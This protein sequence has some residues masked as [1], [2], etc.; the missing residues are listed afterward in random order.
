MTR[1]QRSLPFI[2]VRRKKENIPNSEGDDSVQRKRQAQDELRSPAKRVALQNIEPANEAVTASCQDTKETKAPKIKLRPNRDRLKMRQ[3][4]SC[5]PSWLSGSVMQAAARGR[6]YAVAH[7]AACF[8]Q[9]FVEPRVGARALWEVAVDTMSMLN[10]ASMQA[11]EQRGS[12]LM[13]INTDGSLA[14]V[15]CPGHG[16]MMALPRSALYERDVSRP[17]QMQHICSQQSI[18]DIS[19]SARTPD[20]LATCSSA[21]NSVH[22]WNATT[23][24]CE[25]TLKVHEPLGRGSAAGLQA[26]QT[27]KD[28]QHMLA[29]GGYGGTVHLWDARASARSSMALP[30]QRPVVVTSLLCCPETHT[31]AAGSSRGDLDIWDLRKVGRSSA[32]AV[33][34]ARGMAQAT[35]AATLNLPAAAADHPTA[36]PYAVQLRLSAGCMSAGGLFQGADAPADGAAVAATG[37]D[38]VGAAGGRLAM[39]RSAAVVSA[40]A[41]CAVDR[42]VPDPGDRQRVAFS[43]ACGGAGVLNLAS[44][45]VTHVFNPFMFQPR[46]PHAL[47]GCSKGSAGTDIAWS[48]DSSVLY[49][50]MPQAALDLAA[51]DDVDSG[52]VLRVDG[53]S[54]DGCAGELGGWGRFEG[55]SDG[56]APRRSL[57]CALDVAQRSALCCAAAR[58]WGRGGDAAPFSMEW[59]REGRRGGE[60]GEGGGEAG[61]GGRACMPGSKLG[62]EVERTLYALD[63][64][65]HY[66][67]RQY[68]Q[69]LLEDAKAQNVIV[70][71][72]TGSGKTLIAAL[73]AK[74]F[75]DGHGAKVI[76]MMVPTKLLVGQQAELFR[77]YVADNIGEYT[78]DRG[79]DGWNQE[80]W[81]EEMRTHKILIMTPKILEDLLTCGTVKFWDISL[82]IFDEAHHCSGDHPYAQIMRQYAEAAKPD[83]PHILGMTASP[84]NSKVTSTEKLISSLVGLEK[85]MDS[86][87]ITIH[88]AALKKLQETVPVP[89]TDD[90]AYTVPSFSVTNRQNLMVVFAVQQLLLH[91]DLLELMRQYENLNRKRM[92]VHDLHEKRGFVGLDD[93]GPLMRA[94]EVGHWLVHKLCFAMVHQGPFCATLI[95]QDYFRNCSS[96]GRLSTLGCL[97]EEQQFYISAAVARRTRHTGPRPPR[98]STHAEMDAVV[99]DLNAVLERIR[100]SHPPQCRR[101]PSAEECLRTA[102]LHAVLLCVRMLVSDPV[103]ADCLS[104]QTRKLLFAR[105]DTR[106]AGSTPGH[107]NGARRVSPAG[108]AGAAAAAPYVDTHMH[109]VAAVLDAALHAVP[110]D[111]LEACT[112]GGPQHEVARMW[113][114]YMGCDLVTDRVSKTLAKLYHTGAEAHAEQPDSKWAALVFVQ[115]QTCSLALDML[116]QRV[117]PLKTVLRTNSLRSQNAIMSKSNQGDVISRFRCGVL[118]ALFSTSVAEEGLDIQ[119]CS[120]V[121]CYDVPKRPLSMVQ[122]VGRARSRGSRVFFMR[123]MQESGLKDKHNLDQMEQYTKDMRTAVYGRS[124]LDAALA[125]LRQQEPSE[126]STLWLGDKAINAGRARTMLAQY[127]QALMRWKARWQNLL[128]GNKSTDRRAREMLLSRPRESTVTVSDGPILE[129]EVTLHLPP[130]APVRHITG[131]RRSS[132]VTA[133]ESAVLRMIGALW[134]HGAFDE[135][136][137]PV[138]PEALREVEQELTLEDGGAAGWTSRQTLR[139]PPA[140]AVKRRPPLHLDVR[141]APLDEAAAV[142]SHCF[143]ATTLHL[144][145]FDTT[146]LADSN[147]SG[148][149]GGKNAAAAGADVGEKLELGL[150]LLLLQ[151]LPEL[152]GFTVYDTPPGA[153]GAPVAYECRLRHCR[154][155]SLTMEQLVKVQRF[156]CRMVQTACGTK[157][158]AD[159]L[160]PNDTAEVISNETWVESSGGEYY[161]IV[162]VCEAVEAAGPGKA[163]KTSRAASPRAARCV[164]LDERT[165]ESALHPSAA[166]DGAAAQEEVY[167]QMMQLLRRSLDP[168][169]SPA[170]QAEAQ[171][172]MDELLRGRVLSTLHQPKLAYRFRGISHATIGDKFPDDRQNEYGTFLDYYTRRYEYPPAFFNP[173]APLLRVSIAASAVKDVNCLVRPRPPHQADAAADTTGEPAAADA[174]V[175]GDLGPTD[176]EGVPIEAAPASA[177]ADHLGQ[178]RAAEPSTQPPGQT[179]PAQ[180]G[181]VMDLVSASDES[182]AEAAS[183]AAAPAAA[184]PE[185][186][187]TGAGAARQQPQRDIL[188]PLEVCRV[189]RLQAGLLRSL[190]FLP[191]LIYRVE[192]L[193]AA[194]E[195]WQRL[196]PPRVPEALRRP[197]FT[198]RVLEALTP[199]GTRDS[200][201]SERLEFLG[202]GILKGI[203]AKHVFQTQGGSEGH[204]SLHLCRLVSNGTLFRVAVWTKDINSPHPPT[205]SPSTWRARSITESIR[206]F[207]YD[208]AHWRPPGFEQHAV[209]QR[210][211]LAGKKAADALEALIGIVFETAGEVATELW[212]HHLGMLPGYTGDLAALAAQPCSSFLDDV[213][214]A[215]AESVAVAREMPQASIPGANGRDTAVP[216]RVRFRSSTGRDNSP[217]PEGNAEAPEEDDPQQIAAE[218]AAEQSTMAPESRLAAQFEDLVRLPVEQSAVQEKLRSIIPSQEMQLQMNEA[219]VSAPHTLPPLPAAAPPPLLRAALRSHLQAGGWRA[220]RQQRQVSQQ[221]AA[222]AAVTATKTFRPR[223]VKE[224]RTRS[225]Q[226]I[227]GY[228]FKDVGLMRSSMIHSSFKHEHGEQDRLEFLGDAVLGVCVTT[229]LFHCLG[230]DTRQDVRPAQLHNLRALLVQND[231]LAFIA[232][233]LGLDC[234]L[235]YTDTHLGNCITAFR[236]VV[237]EKLLEK[238]QHPHGRDMGVVQYLLTAGGWDVQ[239][240][241][242]PKALGDVF[243]AALGAVALDCDFHM[244]T[245]LQ[246][247]LHLMDGLRG[248]SA[249]VVPESPVSVLFEAV[250]K[251]APGRKPEFVYQGQEQA[252]APGAP[253]R[254]RGFIAMPSGSTITSEWFS[255]ASR[256]KVKALCA[257]DLLQKLAEAG[258]EQLLAPQ[259]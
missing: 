77:T 189:H 145:V 163:H 15:F 157:G 239:T 253:L 252:E 249:D 218:I 6:L 95:L 181:D 201:D 194:H 256:R 127:C 85:L 5:Y 245:I 250:S 25:T 18:Q 56:A 12:P 190:Q 228:S 81:R 97:G 67:V 21:T 110:R 205:Y 83:R 118:N 231:T 30:L 234:H 93:R 259:A 191:A 92:H 197:E 80:Q 208:R 192:G 257:E 45:T 106:P 223:E 88:D 29:A 34:S 243:E 159:P 38:G 19:W 136:F 84:V 251:L 17:P 180:D 52:G 58:D 215:A 147:C 53:D 203:A 195:L 8:E 175:D 47:P 141:H 171:Q 116:V 89:V 161:I 125:T 113:S 48:P 2:P 173:C 166:D 255:G 41:A 137:R 1:T 9:R 216:A 13:R 202:D 207:R 107:T 225:V 200:L 73:L 68:Q 162:P 184:A 99:R 33:L 20:R 209:P 46:P 146:L 123:A 229:F 258:H 222:M 16:T 236:E 69:D 82:L 31:I 247:V 169:V 242:H 86:K 63:N 64:S 7:T 158:M 24:R 240:L 221:L 32:H 74:H 133:K 108:A 167:E 151:E 3:W 87:L 28:S 36:L 174:E 178:A 105:E 204:M 109:A 102:L 150:G 55:I 214:A 179:G 65:S 193:L 120:L 49:A 11:W 119:H 217:V 244:P 94:E 182:D 104:A 211:E 135:S 238:E 199:Q 66:D 50:V 129:Y 227:L 70:Y 71:L 39:A 148:G 132:R 186:A 23:G 122:T 79:V 14:T 91:E 246:V 152:P 188:L 78:G 206:A 142:G 22:V 4:S 212:L 40:G 144:Y 27:M 100:M 61:G 172:A 143:I 210:A 233:V 248:I 177:P 187:A 117:A 51:Q 114:G 111:V 230:A 168:S 101:L 115:R 57:L 35:P 213:K 76:F 155:L 170:Q 62:A 128:K 121:I 185:A 126:A 37:G 165:I 54:R 131:E 96:D 75:I 219:L 139:Q 160:S 42:L 196:M 237:H 153:G 90:F 60:G 232:V 26:L 140:F 72:E 154:T 220:V 112:L 43:L 130:S 103:L 138:P 134:E 235:L 44:R 176:P 59:K 149:G 241:D 124:T 156:H 224:Q 198:L 226:E 98:G 10:T 254:G 183:G 164:E